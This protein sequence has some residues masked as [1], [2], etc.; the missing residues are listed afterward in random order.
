M[1]HMAHLEATVTADV[2]VIRQKE[3]TYQGSWKREGGLSAWANIKRKIDRLVTMMARPA[4]PGSGFS[5]ENMEDFIKKLRFAQGCQP[6][7]N[8]V[9]LVVYTSPANYAD[10]VQYLLDCYTAGNLH[11]AIRRDPSGADGS[12]L[13]EVRD[14]RRYLLLEE[15]EMVAKGVVEAPVQVTRIV[16]HD[17]TTYNDNPDPSD[18][19][20]ILAEF[21]GVERKQAKDR[22]LAIM[23]QNKGPTV[24]PDCT[25]CHDPVPTAMQHT[26][27]D[28][29]V[30]HLLCY[31]DHVKT[32]PGPGTP[33]DGGHHARFLVD[34]VSVAEEA[35][36]DRTLEDGHLFTSI[37][38]APYP[39]TSS[40]NPVDG[41][42]YYNVD[43]RALAPHL[44]AHLPRLCLELNHKEWSELVP[45]YRGLYRRDEPSAK[46]LLADEYRACWGREP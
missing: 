22:A 20:A 6:N 1:D 33:E 44:W 16:A 45:E 23:Y 21:W 30:W 13:A 8:V 35:G 17:G 39:L 46:W 34:G 15:A 18:I 12:A 9:R 42:T 37:N 4:E 24:L 3:L 25:F 2:E 26:D 40:K 5:V 32:V 43:R 31:R 29:G 11:A 41:A 38:G 28:G 7:N 27:L 14:L 10:F 36:P 19:Y